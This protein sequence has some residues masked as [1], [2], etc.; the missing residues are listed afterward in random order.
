MEKQKSKR[1]LL[2]IMIIA[3]QLVMIGS[4]YASQNTN[5]DE[6]EYTENELK[7]IDKISEEEQGYPYK[8]EVV[9]DVEN[10][11]YSFQAT[12]STHVTKVHFIA[13]GGEKIKQTDG[14]TKITRGDA[15]LIENDGEYALIDTGI[16]NKCAE[17]LDKYRKEK[18]LKTL[19]LKYVILTHHHN[20]HYKG[21]KYIIKKDNIKVKCFIRQKDHD[22]ISDNKACKSDSYKNLMKSI[23]NL[24]AKGTNFNKLEYIYT[25]NVNAVE[26]ATKTVKKNV[27]DSTLYIYRPLRKTTDANVAKSDPNN[28]ENNRSIIC[29]LESGSRKYLFTGDVYNEAILRIVEYMKKTW[30]QMLNT[31]VLKLQ[32]H[33]II[34]Y[35]YDNYENNG[36]NQTNKYNSVVNDIYKNKFN[37]TRYY[38]TNPLTLN[39]MDGAKKFR[40]EMLKKE[41]GGR[42]NFVLQSVAKTT[43]ID[44]YKY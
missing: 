40:N 37:A 36:A 21:L 11:I 22:D 39:E 15:I 33:G 1:F 19:N 32:H 16:D 5:Y 24:N 44:V 20:D 3:L 35:Y 8:T 29:R 42:K 25:L 34:N 2:I 10:K 6:G 12:S 30:P 28:Y 13:N 31:Y 38:L 4:V 26:N 18:G 17:Y 7:Q 43:K 27:G 14:S 41:F 23:N 9:A